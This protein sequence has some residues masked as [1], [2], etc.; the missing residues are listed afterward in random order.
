MTEFRYSICDPLKPEIQEMGT[1]TKEEFIRVMNDFDWMKMLNSLN[2]AESNGEKIFF[3][4]SLE[5]ENLQTKQ[6][7]TVSIIGEEENHEFYIFYRRPKKIKTALGLIDSP[8]GL[9][10]TSDYQEQW[11]ED[12]EDAFTVLLE[13]DTDTLEDRWG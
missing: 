6:G 8:E 4:P 7:I 3:S 5:L 9:Y 12:A 1:V 13:G 11:M 10:E 2:Q